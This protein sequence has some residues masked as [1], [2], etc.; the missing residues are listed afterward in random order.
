MFGPPGTIYVFLSYGVHY[1]L[2]VVC[3]RSG[4]GSAVLIRSLEALSENGRRR[5]GRSA[6][7]GNTRKQHFLRTGASGKGLG[8]PS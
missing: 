5:R 4:S 6:G 8:Y 3:D 1:L 2:N 7:R